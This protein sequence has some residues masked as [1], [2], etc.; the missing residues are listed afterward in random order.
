MLP[1]CLKESTF[2][3]TNYKD[4][5]ISHDGTLSADNGNTLNVVE[6]QTG[7]DSWKT[8]GRYYIV[9]DIL[10]RYMD[11][12]LKSLTEV[13]IKDATPYSSS[14]DSED[15]VIV[16]DH[17]LSGGYL[18]LDLQYY[19][20]PSSNYARSIDF[21]WEG[22]HGNLT[23]YIV[24]QGNGEN[25]SQ[26]DINSL[27]TEEKLFSIPLSELLSDGTYYSLSLCLHELKE[28]SDGSYSVEQNTYLLSGTS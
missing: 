10:N 12:R 3:L 16:V 7:S 26:M 5:V 18:N 23:I 13:Q 6:N 20:D 8:P 22:D 11:I 17:T 27:K 4:F 19:Y 25:P 1:S 15:P 24:Y 14:L 28:N 21:Y 9:C 2:S